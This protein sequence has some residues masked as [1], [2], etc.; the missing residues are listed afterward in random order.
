M[1]I[2]GSY[3]PL[4]LDDA[5]ERCAEVFEKFYSAG[6]NVIR[7][8]LHAS[9]NLTSK[10]S[11][12]AGPNHPALGELVLN[13]FFYKRISKELQKLDVKDKTVMI[14]V[15]RGVLS[16]AVGQ[17]QKNKKKLSAEFSAEII[18][19]ESDALSNYDFSVERKKRCI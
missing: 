3:E 7:I 18:F 12:L 19:S 11:C 15:A 2:S 1:A 6:V 8:G 10:D 13:E 5:V 17:K 16:K 4:S 14:S 9:E